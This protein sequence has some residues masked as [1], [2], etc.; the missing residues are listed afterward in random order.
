MI[1]ILLSAEPVTNEQITEQDAPA[2][3]EEPLPGTTTPEQLDLQ[4][5]AANVMD[6]DDEEEFS[7]SVNNIPRHDVR[8]IDSLIR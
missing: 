5:T 3:C 6:E 2:R 7:H 1:I 4:A 8:R